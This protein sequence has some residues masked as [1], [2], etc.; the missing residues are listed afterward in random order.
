MRVGYATGYNSWI[1]GAV[2]GGYDLLRAPTA[3]VA[4]RVLYGLRELDAR[5]GVATLQATTTAGYAARC[6]VAT[7]C[8]ER[9]QIES[10]VIATLRATLPGV[11]GSDIRESLRFIFQR[12]WI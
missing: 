11:R 5:C 1:R 12:N 8:Y 4:A 6:G 3:R 7:T 10:R 2:R 9:R